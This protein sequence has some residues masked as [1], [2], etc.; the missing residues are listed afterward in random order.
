MNTRL[1]VVVRKDLNMTPGL[2]A[3][4]VAHISD[5]FMRQR[6]LDNKEFSVDERNWMQDPYI[7]VLAVDN[8]EE[9]R[10]IQKDA[11]EASLTVHQ[12]TDLIPM[13]NINK[14]LPNV[15]VGISIGPDDFDRIKAVTGNLPLA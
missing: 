5:E 6:I 2:L 12:W 9:L 15:L 8:P 7:S 3:A 4:Q 11:A 10:S 14:A 13:K 1:T